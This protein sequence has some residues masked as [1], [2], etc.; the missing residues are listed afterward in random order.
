MD[1]QTT[2]R[3]IPYDAHV[4][5]SLDEQ[6][7]APEQC[8]R[9]AEAAGLQAVGLVARFGEVQ[10]SPDQWRERLGQLGRSSPVQLLAGVQA[11]LLDA[12]G[13]LDI[14]SSAAEQF[15]LVLAHLSER[16]AG[17]GHDVPVR[18][19][20]LV[21]NIFAALLG[22]VDEGRCNVLAYPFNLGRF[23]APITPAQLPVERVEQLGEAMA[24]AEVACELSN[25]AWWWYPELTVAQFTEDFA[26]VLRAFS[27]GG[28]KFIV[29]SDSRDV[30]GVGNLRYV[31]RLM[32]E[33]GVELSQL[34]DLTRL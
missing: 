10:S 34:V 25:R 26:Q 1:R 4:N 11:E 29:G 24:E 8:L 12:S 15:P 9:A 7:L 22:V 30:S 13:H 27:R 5:T 3:L 6:G 31:R 16:T 21:D 33:A 18:W 14:S 19:E 17:I 32:Q 2:M 28:V 20:R 23:P